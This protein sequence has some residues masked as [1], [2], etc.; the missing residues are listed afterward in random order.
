MRRTG[1]FGESVKIGTD[2]FW[3]SEC[4][5]SRYMYNILFIGRASSVFV[6]PCCFISLAIFFALILA[7]AMFSYC[8]LCYMAKE[9]YLKVKVVKSCFF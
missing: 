2:V 7:A 4:G 3:C 5:H 9:L 1:F 8:W 6:T